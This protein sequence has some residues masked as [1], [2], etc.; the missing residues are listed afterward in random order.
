MQREL[1]TSPR[2][3][4]GTDLC[5]IREDT[6]QLICDY[7]SKFHFVY[8]IEGKVTSDRIISKMSE[9]FAENGSPS[10]VVSDNGGHYSSQAFRNFAAAWC[11]DHVTSSPHFPQSNGLIERQVQTMK[12]TVKKTAMARSNPQ[13]ALLTFRSTPVDSHLPSPAEMLIARKYKSNLPVIIRN[14]RRN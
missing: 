5:A 2:K 7:Y 11:F 13:K 6:Y 10:K 14:E 12:Y 9:V 4:V 8:R 1:P 3:I